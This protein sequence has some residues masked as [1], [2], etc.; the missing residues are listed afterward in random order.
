MC[1]ICGIV[2]FNTTPIDVEALKKMNQAQVHRGPDDEG[3]YLTKNAGLGFRRLSI[4]DLV[5]GNQPLHNEDKMIWA[6]CN[7]ELYNYQEL[8]KILESK[9]HQFY[10][11]S[12]AEVIVHLY[13]EYGDDF[14]KKLRKFEK[15]KRILEVK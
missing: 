6:V 15:L 7:G 12:D 2:N 11:K 3:Y 14:L 5:T 13:E 4:I 9:S 10:T 1:G 8:K